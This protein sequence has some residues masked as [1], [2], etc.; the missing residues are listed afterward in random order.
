MCVCRVGVW[1]DTVLAESVHNAIVSF[2]PC[3][4]SLLLP[5]HYC[6]YGMLVPREVEERLLCGCTQPPLQPP[7]VTPY[8]M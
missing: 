1:S 7:E 6:K 4:S 5:Q 2:T 3:Y 8:F